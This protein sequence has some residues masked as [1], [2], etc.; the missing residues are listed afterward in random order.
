M[1]ALGFCDIVA[2]EE[3]DELAVAGPED[4]TFCPHSLTTFLLFNE[5]R[6]TKSDISG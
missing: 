1:V 4:D 5:S 3:D 2:V 6:L